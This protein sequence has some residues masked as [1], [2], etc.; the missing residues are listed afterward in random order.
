MT[1]HEITRVRHETRLRTLT[2]Q[3]IEQL[4]TNMLRIYFASN[5]L[6]D[7]VSAS[8]DDHI[9]IFLPGDGARDENNKP[10]MRD[11]TPRRFD[12]A[13]G[14][15]TIDFALHDTGPA[16]AWA[17]QATVGDTLE[18]G[19]PRGSVIIPEDFD[20]YLLI[21]DETA[22]PAIG[23]RVEELATSVP[24]FTYVVLDAADEAQDFTT[25]ADWH[26]NWLVR[27]DRDDADIVLSALANFVKPGGDGFVWIAAEATVA[28]SLRN[29]VESDMGQNRNWIKAAGYWQRGA[30]GAHVRIE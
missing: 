2:V 25:A 26:P 9:K 5:D 13:A 29:F 18:I 23:R 19:G 30:D 27:D 3:S 7:F 22:L 15:L 24:V 17:R 16:V 20:W 10:P 11:F 28:K 8:F 1:R 4:S 12:A 6:A 14:T 21:G